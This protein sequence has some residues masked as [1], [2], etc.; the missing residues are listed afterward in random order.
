MGCQNVYRVEEL[1]L[2]A[3]TS[4]VYC[5][6]HD[7][8]SITE[9][10][11]GVAMWRFITEVKKLDGRN[12]PPK[13][14]RDI[15]PCVQFHLDLKGYTDK[16]LDEFRFRA[17]RYTLDNMMKIRCEEGLGNI[18]RQAEVISFQDE[19]R[20][21]IMGILGTER[22]EQLVHTFIYVLGIACALRAGKEHCTLR[23]MAFSSRFRFTFDCNGTHYLEQFEGIR[24]VLPRNI[25]LMIVYL[26]QQIV[27]CP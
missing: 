12:F 18:V 7:V 14:L 4:V 15:V 8:S 23:S 19:D 3:A 10:S 1:S 24:Q 21:W 22:P 5:D 25:R 2:F 20:M 17:V 13:T 6:L 9:D 11:V 27:I 26:R 16:L